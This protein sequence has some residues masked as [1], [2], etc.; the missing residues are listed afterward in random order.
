MSSGG[1][2]DHG[3]NREKPTGVW[4]RDELERDGPLYVKELHRRFTHWCKNRGYSPASYNSFRRTV[5]LLKEE[6]LVAVA[7]TEPGGNPQFA[8]RRYYRVAP[9]ADRDHPAWRDPVKERY[10]RD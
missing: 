8:D 5:W 3:F 6:G 1:Q 7:R 9:G 10:G 2:P 4:I